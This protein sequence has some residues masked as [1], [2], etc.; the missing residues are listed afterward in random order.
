MES[1]SSP[2]GRKFTHVEYPEPHRD[3][4]RKILKDHPEVRQLFGRQPLSAPLTVGIVAFQVVT[5]IALR[6]QPWWMVI[7]VAWLV[8][9][10]LTHTLWVLIHEAT[11]NLMVESKFSN[12]ALGVIANLPMLVPSAESFR[13]YHLKHHKFQGDYELDAD[14][15]SHWEAKL[16][17]SSLVG[18]LIWQLFFPIFQSLRVIRFS[19]A[20]NISFVT[21]GVITNIVASFAFDGAIFYF[22]GPMAL[23]Y[24]GMSLVFSIGP[25]PVGARWIQEHYLTWDHDQETGSYYGP[26]NILAL[27]VGYHNEHHDFPF[28]PWHKLPALKKLAPEM[29]DTLDSYKSY[30]KLWILFLTTPT[31]TLFSRVT[32]DGEV[33][34]K[35]VEI[36]ERA[37]A[38]ADVSPAALADA[39][40]IAVSSTAE[41]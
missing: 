19:K 28:I 16:I 3:R 31:V 2:R 18:K 32:R 4:A 39:P 1:S 23:L 22:F 34:L 6:N 29:Y 27:N 17:G 15:P 36:R 35:R 11:H 7:G 26:A 20:G 40:P 24:L 30:T 10:W 38:K 33:N 12:R 41:A 21:A 9:A 8:G 14:L 13:I 25:H 37:A 5:A